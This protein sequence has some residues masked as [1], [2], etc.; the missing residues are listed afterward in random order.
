MRNAAQF[1]RLMF[2]AEKNRKKNTDYERI[3]RE[4]NPDSAPHA[5]AVSIQEVFL[6]DN[7]ASVTAEHRTDSVRYHHK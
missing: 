2:V 5:V 1:F 7:A 6:D 4:C 3:Q